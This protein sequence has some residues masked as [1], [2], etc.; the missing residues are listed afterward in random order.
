MFKLILIILGVLVAV[1]SENQL[2]I[3]ILIIG[4]L[5]FILLTNKNNPNIFHLCFGFMAVKIVE[6]IIIENILIPMYSDDTL[7][8]MRM[9]A[10][11]FSLHFV[12]DLLFYLFVL[13]RAP[14][15]R[16]VLLAKNKS[17]D[18]IYMYQSEFAFMS[19]FV[20]LMFIDLAALLE[21]F[22]RHL[23]EIGFSA[24]IAEQFYDWTWIYYH[25]SDIKSSLAG[26]SFILLWSMISSV[27]QKKYTPSS[28]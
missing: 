23:D 26:I 15:S 4:S 17:T 1:I 25:Y 27:G 5:L 12:T 2:L 18:N 10:I 24:E 21:N 28:S 7:S 6:M 3:R 20:V 13:F 11:I 16:M 19:L 8:S 14:L 9:N 22:I